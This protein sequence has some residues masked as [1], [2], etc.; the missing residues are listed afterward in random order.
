MYRELLAGYD[1][2]PSSAL[3]TFESNGF[4]DLVTVNEIGFYSLC[5]HHLIPFFG[6]FHIGYIPSGRMLG[7]SKFA[8]VVD[9]YSHRLQTQE[10]LTQQVA[11]VLDEGLNPAGL[12]VHVEAEHL[13]V[14]MRGVKKNEFITK[15][16]V[17]KGR[18]KT[19]RVLLD[20][21]YRSFEPERRNQ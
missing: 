5:E 14:S 20:T 12:T 19:D 8:R 17:T 21:F 10:N 6:T 1:Q 7:L 2:D 3:K 13:C 9:I 18:M 4:S 15:T 11:N 16:T